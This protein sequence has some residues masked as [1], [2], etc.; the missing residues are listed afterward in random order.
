MFAERGAHVIDTDA[1]V[2]ELSAPGGA[3]WGPLRAR[4]GPLDRAGLADLAF[5][6]PA[7][8]RDLNAILHPLVERRVRSRLAELGGVVVVEVPLLVE[9]GWQGMFDAVVVVDAPEEV[10]VQRV[11]ASRGMDP[12][13]V[14]RRM[15]AQASRAERRAAADHVIVNDG[16]LA[17]LEDQV[18]SVLVALDHN[19]CG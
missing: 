6:D 17:A 12:A 9:A 14:R 19:R 11:A 15:A 16:P 2:R 13:D 5:S 4:F 1:I 3:A 7:A 10:A 18:A 8:R